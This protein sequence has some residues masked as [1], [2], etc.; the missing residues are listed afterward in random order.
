MAVLAGRVARAQTAGSGFAVDRFE[1]AGGGS[2]WF[3]LESLDF[4]GRVR[5]ALG[6][7]IDGAW[8]PLVVFDQNGNPVATMLRNQLVG[9]ADAAVVLKDRLRL[10]VNLPVVVYQQGT[11]LILNDQSYSAPAH[12]GLGDVR[13]GADLRLYGQSGGPLIAAAGVQ[14]FAPNGKASAFTGDGHWR[15]WPRVLL[16]GNVRTLSWAARLGYH[17]RPTCDC[18]LA[19]GD[20]LTAA[21]AV[22]V[23]PSSRLLIGPEI[24]VS[25][26]RAHL[27][28]AVASPLELLVGAHFAVAPGWTLGA[29]VAPGLTDGPGSPTVRAIIGLQYF[30]PMPAPAVAPRLVVAPPTPTPARKPAARPAPPP[31]PP[32]PPPPDQDGDGIPDAEDACPAEEGAK[33]EDLKKNGCLVP[34]DTDGDGI[35][36]PQDACPDQPGPAQRR[37]DAKRMSGGADRKRTNPDT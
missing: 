22:G 10:D 37:P 9:H 31:P 4:R 32:P 3:S 29:G 33:S 2:E 13:L 17:I 36:D 25:T 7:V 20:E 18:S 27:G 21:I 19:P 1:P 24:Y 28:E 6:L 12:Q 8:K 16:A 14:A 35:D 26:A 30:A 11:G 34:K 23:R 15:F 5:P